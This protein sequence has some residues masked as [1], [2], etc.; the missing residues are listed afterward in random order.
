[1][2]A[3]RDPRAAN[4]GGRPVTFP[5]LGGQQPPP[6][7]A[8][9]AGQLVPGVQPG[10]TQVFV[11]LRAGNTIIN[12]SGV[13]TYSGTPAAGNLIATQAP[14]AGT[15]S[16][17]NNYLEGVSS[18]GAAFASAL[19]GGGL[20]FY[21]GSLAGGWS[22]EGELITDTSGDLLSSFTGAFVLSGDLTASTINGSADTGTAL[23]AGVPTG[24]PTTG[25]FST[26]AHDF[27]GHTHPI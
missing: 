23:P 15:D 5:G 16:F 1:M 24:G 12:A 13:F 9:P 19:I 25:T 2:A 11:Q 7:N 6:Q 17:G 14:A 3:P 8:S 26:H 27:D 18:Y 10:T 4:P 22:A 21:T 20:I